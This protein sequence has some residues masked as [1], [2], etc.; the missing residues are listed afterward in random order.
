MYVTRPLSHFRRFPSALSTAPEG[1]NSGYLV[2]L[3]D[4]AE[5]TC[6]FGSCEDPRIYQLPF[7]QNKTF[8]VRFTSSTGSNG[9]SS[10][11]RDVIFIPVINQPLSSNLYYAIEPH[12]RLKGEVQSNLK[13][14]EVACCCWNELIPDANLELFDPGN[15]RQHFM[16]YPYESLFNSGCFCARSVVQD[17]CPPRFLSKKG[18]RLYTDKSIYMDEAL[19]VDMSSRARHPS[20]DFPLDWTRSMGMVVGKW[21]CPFL[22]VRDGS[23]ADQVKKS[24]FYEMT[25]K[26][27][28]EQVYACE[29]IPQRDTIVVDVVIEDEVV[30][31]G[32]NK[33]EWRDEVGGVMWF[34]GGKGE[35]DKVGLSMAIVER[36]KWEEERA[37]W[38]GGEGRKAAVR[39]EVEIDR[40]GKRLGCYML[41]E[42]FVLRR[43]DGSVALTYDFMHSHV[44]NTKLE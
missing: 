30:H 38:V 37:G 35:K 1:P 36:M 9:N 2:V 13:A 28:W 43:M 18:W 32:G 25:L 19:G 27:R 15:V 11:S 34:R 3:D 42:R 41:V 21:Y 8:T 20:L 31:V 6:C 16:I 5:N 44:I 23:L 33:A 4:E 14:E 40:E 29:N 24:M 10:S 39:T 26:Q 22:F 17:G 7:P 12:G